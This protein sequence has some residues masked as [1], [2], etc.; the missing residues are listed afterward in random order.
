LK[1]VKEFLEQQKVK[2]DVL[3]ITH[4]EQGNL[5]INRLWTEDISETF[6][7]IR[8]FF[9]ERPYKEILFFLGTPVAFAFGLGAAFGHYAKG[10]IYSYYRDREPSYVEVLRLE[11]IKKIR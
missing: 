3:L 4:K 6:T 7:V 8:K 5:S 2:N 9:S 11:E 10:S 1:K